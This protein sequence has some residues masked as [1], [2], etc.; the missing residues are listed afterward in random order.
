[1]RLHSVIEMP[2]RAAALAAEPDVDVDVLI[3]EDVEDDAEER[4][5]E[6]WKV[7]LYNDDIHSFDEVILQLIKATGCSVQKATRIAVKAHVTGKALAFT[8]TFDECFRV[9][10]ILR[11]IQLVT[12]IEG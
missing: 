7:I 8:G 3:E 4:L 5:D 9:N 6:P 1:M 10:G 11:E 12:E 2:W